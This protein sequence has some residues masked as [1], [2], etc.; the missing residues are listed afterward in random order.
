MDAVSHDTSEVNQNVRDIFISRF[1]PGGGHCEQRP[2]SEGIF[3]LSENTLS[4]L[5]RQILRNAPKELSF[6]TIR[7]PTALRLSGTAFRAHPSSQNDE[8]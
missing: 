8:Q 5:N 6:L 2:C 7:S 1:D 3:Q 4:I